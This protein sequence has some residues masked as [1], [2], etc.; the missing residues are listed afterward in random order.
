MKKEQMRVF[1]E[2]GLV[3]FVALSGGNDFLEVDPSGMIKI[4]EGVD[5][6][7][8]HLVV[9]VK[10]GNRTFVV[11]KNVGETGGAYSSKALSE[12]Q[13]FAKGFKAVAMRDPI[14]VIRAGNNV[15]SGWHKN[16]ASNRV[17]CWHLS[18]DGELWLFQVGVLTHDNGK[19]WVLHGEYRWKGQLYQMNGQLVGRPESSKWGS[20]EGGT[21]KRTQIFQHP[22]FV[23]LLDGIKAL[24]TWDGDEAELD[25][26]LPKLPAGSFAAVDWFIMFAGQTGQGIVKDIDG[27]P[28]WVHGRN[29]EG[30]K[31]EDFEP[32]LWHG[33]VISFDGVVNNW[34]KKQNSPPMLTGVRLVER[35]W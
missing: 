21:S 2:T 12:L 7:G 15:W 18:A 28:A 34:G 31:S 23:V 24:P 9:A 33:D 32:L 11:Q 25:P 19:T 13:K 10:D 3:A 27:N 14:D 1:G 29:I 22:D 17:D 4:P 35:A 5:P 26:P 6:Q 8:F 30:F 20:L 16:A